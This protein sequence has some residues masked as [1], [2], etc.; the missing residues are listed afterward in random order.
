MQLARRR[1][2]RAQVD[3]VFDDLIDFVTEFEHTIREKQAAFQ[4][5]VAIQAISKPGELEEHEIEALQNEER[6]LVDAFPQTLRVAS[7]ALVHSA[8]ETQ[9]REIAELLQPIRKV[10]IRLNDL[11]GSQSEKAESY[12]HRVCGIPPLSAEWSEITDYQLVRNAFVHNQGQLNDRAQSPNKIREAVKRLSAVR[13]DGDQI[14]L[15]EDFAIGYA[16][17]AKTLCRNILQ[18]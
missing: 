2:R 17:S 10:E 13:I 8:L 9:L 6:Q 12:F 14:I 18:P 7:T 1:Q 11:N 3:E 16:K 5:R 15:E 4:A